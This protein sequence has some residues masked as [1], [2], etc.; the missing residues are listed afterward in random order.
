MFGVE[1]LTSF[2]S[3]AFKVGYAIV[4]A[5]VFRIAWNSTAL[6]VCWNIVSI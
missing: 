2:I 6:E 1:Y 3:M 5:I 4:A